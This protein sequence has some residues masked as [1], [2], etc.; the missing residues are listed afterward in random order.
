MI[1]VLGK[2]AVGKTSLIFRFINNRCP[3]EHDPTVED[4]Y[5]VKIEVAEGETQEFKILDTAGEED[6]QNLMDQWI[7]SAKGFIL[8]YAVN[9]VES[10]D[11]IKLIFKRIEKNEA[12]KLPIILVGNKCDIV[13]KRTVSTQQG[14]DLA[15]SIGA[16]YFETSALN[17]I[18]GNIKTVFNKMAK[19]IVN[20]NDLE[21]E[22]KQK[23]LKCNIF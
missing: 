22:G 15:K 8:V 9:D 20:K 17:D 18:N 23:C 7:N 21:E 1:A 16:E 12:N 6:Y 3:K 13:D 2:G 5:T 11:G 4:S 14:K 19:M 10:L